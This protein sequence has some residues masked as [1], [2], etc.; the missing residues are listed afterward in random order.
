MPE[1]ANIIHERVEIVL[2]DGQNT[3]WPTKGC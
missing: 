3:F 2:V 1:K